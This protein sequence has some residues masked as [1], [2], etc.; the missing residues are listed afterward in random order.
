[1]FGPNENID[2][3][4]VVEREWGRDRYRSEQ[5][6]GHHTIGRRLV[7]SSE[8][9]VC[10]ADKSR[11]PPVRRMSVE[12]IRCTYL[13]YMPVAEHRNSITHDKCF[14]LVVCNEDGG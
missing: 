8:H 6:V 1:L 3:T 11:N 4:V 12:L 10:F 2:G 5:G 13:L 9:E 14:V 7:H